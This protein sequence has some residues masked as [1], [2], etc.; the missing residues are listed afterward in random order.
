MADFCQMWLTCGTKKEADKIAQT[1]LNKRLITCARQVQAASDYW[2]KGKVD[3]SNE[4]L[5]QM[6]SRLDLFDQVEDEVKKIHSY[7]TFVLET[8][9]ISKASKEAMTWF[10][11][12][13]KNE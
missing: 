6:E 9:P 10:N 8:T 2:W 3:H 7:E 5:L 1:L 12:E 13:L 11:S 4:I